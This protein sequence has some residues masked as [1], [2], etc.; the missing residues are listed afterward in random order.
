MDTLD[1]AQLDSAGIA[2]RETLDRLRA[3]VTRR[4]G[5]PEVAADITQDVIVR[6]IAAGALDDVDDP[7]AW[8][9][10]SARNAIV[11][12]YRTRRAHLPLDETTDE[13]WVDDDV[14]TDAGPSAATRELSKCLTPLLDR[15]PDSARDALERVEIAGQTQQRAA[16][17]AGVS[18]SGMKSRVQ[19]GRRALRD[20]LEECCAVEVDRRGG[21]TG[22]EPQVPGCGCAT[23]RSDASVRRG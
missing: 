10:R 2:W 22:F 6:S 4:V 19:R 18:L 13:P 21:I 12:H 20:L 3:F 8:L 14:D 23:T 11:D 7:V 1:T 5:D 16:R 17:D 15:L 9:Y